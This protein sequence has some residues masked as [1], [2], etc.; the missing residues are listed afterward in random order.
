MEVRQV[1]CVYQVA[2]DKKTSR[3]WFFYL[4][5]YGY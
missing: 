3:S 4:E 5:K 2:A 1:R